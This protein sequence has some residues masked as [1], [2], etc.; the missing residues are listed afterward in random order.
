MRLF[1]EH[2]VHVL[3]DGQFGSTGKGALA[4]WLAHRAFE[5]KAE[6][7]AVVTNAGPNS[8]HTSYHNGT[9]IV[10]KQLPTFAVISHLLG[11]TI[12]VYFSA[13]AVI[14][15]PILMQEHGR[16][17]AI[18]IYIHGA[19]T[20]LEEEDRQHES[21]LRSIASVAGTRS[22]TGYAIAQK[23]MRVPER[24]YRN[25]GWSELFPE[26]HA[27]WIKPEHTRVFM[28]ISQGFSLGLNT[29]EFYPKVTSRECTFAQG[30]ADARVAM[31]HFARGFLS[32]RT[33]PIRV[34][35]VD[36][37]SSGGWYPDQE[38][39]TWAYIGEKPELTTVT[40]RERRIATW[41][42]VQFEE[43]MDANHP[44]HVFLNFMNYLPI[45]QRADFVRRHH[46]FRSRWCQ[47]T[48]YQFLLGNGPKHTD[49]FEYH[50]SND[51]GW[52]R[53]VS[54]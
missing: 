27:S 1:A 10:L 21:S 32:F 3:A 29:P 47:Y 46:E 35:N 42:W 48:E 18:P 37:Y 54:E 28:E 25:S 6:F 33:F 39:T 26:Y 51:P 16:F 8:G 43:A 15:A 11:R 19:A 12:P 9:Q 13:G 4:C 44:T 40:K 41:S 17:P 45:A 22:G 38:E 50:G 2:G 5:E 49:I 34:G 52:M 23:V 24:I 7:S 31:K 14:D 30:F 36:G 53:T 20:T